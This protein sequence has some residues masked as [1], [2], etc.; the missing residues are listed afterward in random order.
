M[1]VNVSEQINTANVGSYQVRIVILCALVAL[2]DGLDIQTMAIVAPRMAEDWGLP[3]SAFGPVL[4]ASFA[5]IMLGTASL[6]ALGDRIGRRKVVIGAFLIVGIASMLTALATSLA[7]LM[8]LRFITG[9]A[10]GGCLPNITALTSEFVPAKR[11]GLAVTL[12]YSAVPLGGVLGSFIAG[13][14]IELIDWQGIFILG[15]VIPLVICVAL[16][17]ALPES[18]RFMVANDGDPA[19]VGKLLAKVDKRYTYEQGH[20][21]VIDSGMHKGRVSDLFAQGRGA[22]TLALWFTFFFGMAI[23]YL[24]ASWLPSI[25][26][27]QGWPMAEAIRTVAFFQLGGIVGGLFAGWMLD[28]VGA[29]AVLI[30]GYSI[31]AALT[32][33]VG[34][35]GTNPD[36]VRLL[37]VGAGFGI[38]GSTLCLTAFA[39]MLYPTAIRST[40]VGWALGVGRLGAVVSPM[41]GGLALAADWGQAT[42][43]GVAAI[44]AVLCVGGVLLLLALHRRAEA[45]APR[46]MDPE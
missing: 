43:F 17:F 16:V 12:M 22:P 24:L 26:R 14:L 44:P 41:A 2:L 8:I 15:G 20:R 5:G 34:L 10:I 6:G 23:M 7:P 21:F 4:S 1:N 3:T 38:V 37:V 32:L 25:F 19:Q 28:R 29:H 46:N 31:G 11:V 36:I 33:A 45:L 39:A 18:I 40:G 30:G 35:Y 9:F 27:N 13:D 42:L